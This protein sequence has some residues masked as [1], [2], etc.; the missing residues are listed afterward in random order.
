[1]SVLILI[2][3]PLLY[4]NMFLELPKGILIKLLNIEIIKE[5]L[6]QEKKLK[7]FLVIKH[8]SKQLAF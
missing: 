5:N 6:S 2:P 4:L 1:M 8:M 7:K 3:P